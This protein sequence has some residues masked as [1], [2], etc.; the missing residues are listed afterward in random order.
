MG[1]YRSIEQ[2]HMRPFITDI[3]TAEAAVRAYI[4][5]TLVDHPERLH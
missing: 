1:A 3:D 5:G 2:A 4:D